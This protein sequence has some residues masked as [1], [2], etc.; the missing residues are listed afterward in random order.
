LFE[1]LGPYAVLLLVLPVAALVAPGFYRT[2]NLQNVVREASFLAVVALGQLIVI[3]AR[4]L[5]LSVGAVITTA[6]LLIIEIAGR[7]GGRALLGLIA[8]LIFGAAVGAVNAVMVA[9]RR[10][11]AILATLATAV[12]VEGVVLWLTEGQSRGRVPDLI[13]S[14][15]TGRIGPVP[16]PVVIAAAA[17]VLVTLLLRRSAYGRSLYAVGSNPGA[18]RFSG[19]P[20][21]WISASS[22]LLCSMLA[23]VAGLMLAGY[24]GFYDRTLGT[25]YELDSIAAVVLGGASLAGGRGTV[26]GTLAAALGLAALD[27]LLLIRGVGEPFQLIGKGLVLFLAVLFA[28]FILAPSRRSGGSTDNV[29]IPPERREAPA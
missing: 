19:V 15:G 3:I 26:G 4:G 7:A 6:S 23:V 20:V 18:S 10:V 5:D 11:P 1:A 27:N 12:V 21:R 14:M 13:R 8:V 2:A 9:Y 24:V 28:Q 17:A 16:V 29:G 22:F 25:G